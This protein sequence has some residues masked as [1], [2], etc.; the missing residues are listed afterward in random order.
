MSQLQRCKDLLADLAKH[1]AVVEQNINSNIHST[2]LYVQP[3][4]STAGSSRVPL[5]T[6]SEHQQVFG[7]APR[8]APNQRQAKKN[9]RNGQTRNQPPAK[10][11]KQSRTYT[12]TFWCLS[13]TS[14][15]R[16]PSA[17]EYK[18]LNVVYIGKQ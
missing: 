17:E 4:I 10:R 8:S 2:S 16:M 5:A 18:C 6:V 14:S 9:E 1:I 13:S 15:D 12:R 11:G 7:Y 3:A